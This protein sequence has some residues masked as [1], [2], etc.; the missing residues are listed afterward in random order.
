MSR[1]H[2]TPNGKRT[3]ELL[4]QLPPGLRIEKVGRKPHPQVLLADGTPLRDERGMPICVAGTCSSNER[5][6][7]HEVERI[8]RALDHRAWRLDHPACTCG[9]DPLGN[10]DPNCPAAS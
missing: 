6:L 3:R 1:G 4:R 2:G 9:T 7:A 8:R 10:H 5:M